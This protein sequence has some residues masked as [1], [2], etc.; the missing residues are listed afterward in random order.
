MAKK[1]KNITAKAVQAT[2]NRPLPEVQPKPE[3][4]E[5]PWGNDGLTIRQRLFV[6][7]ILGTAGGNASKAAEMAGYS[8]E[9]R[10]ALRVTAH[11]VL[12]HANVQRAVAHRLASMLA[13][14]EW[15]RL[16]LV[17]IAS[18][19]MANFLTRDENGRFVTDLDKAAAIGALG[20]IRE[21]KEESLKVGDS[22]A[23][24]IK[25][26]IKLHDA[27]AANIALAKLYG[28]IVEKHEHSGPGG[29][30]IEATVKIQS[31]LER[32]ADEFD[33]FARRPV[34]DGVLSPNGN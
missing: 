17:S 3:V 10:N 25:Q 1:R 27:T 2:E 11:R 26:T 14:P 19:S 18:S 29:G 8:A 4:D 20:Q 6:K 33:R 23:T 13:S 22:P 32:C 15:V 12:T 9:N 30:P 21:I 31:D 24:I 34:G 28:L 5:D 16:N 7:A